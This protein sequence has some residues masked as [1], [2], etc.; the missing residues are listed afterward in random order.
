MNSPTREVY[1]NE[2]E[3][4]ML[5]RRGDGDAWLTLVG[6][7]QEAVFR[8][9]WLLLG[10]ADEA[11]DVA[12]E[13]FIRAFHALDRFDE[14]RPLRPWLLQIAKNLTHNQ[15]RA[16]QRYLAAAKRWFDT[17]STAAPN[18]E[19]VY[20]QQQIAEV[21]R[22]AVTRLRPADQEVI[23]LRYFMAL[24]VAESA[25]VLDIAEGTVKSRLS[26]ATERLRTVVEEEFPSLREADLP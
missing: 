6:C 13:T 16:V 2:T 14:T 21:L 8:M 24:T 10:D 5:A 3:Q 4:I 20:T 26:R 25:Q 12:Q 17:R 22:Q 18:P 7:H 19:L 23:Y 9:A 15:R 1:V 11:A